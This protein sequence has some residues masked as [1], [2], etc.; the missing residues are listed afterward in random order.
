MAGS[1]F[2]GLEKLYGEGVTNKI[3]GCVFHHKNSVKKKARSRGED[4]EEFKLIDKNLLESSTPDPYEKVKDKMVA[5]INKKDDLNI[6]SAWF[7]WLDAR[8]SYIFRAFQGLLK[9]QI[10]LAETIHPG[11]VHRDTI[12]VNLLESSYYDIR[13]NLLFDVDVKSFKEGMR[14]TGSGLSQKLAMQRKNSH[15]I[16]YAKQLG[17]NI[18]IWH[19]FKS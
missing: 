2:V 18:R 5:F 9:P 12:N 13:N 7:N 14:S 6:L 3:K 11:M 19:I 16:L 10:N 1:K 15:E 17:K 8:K 4:G